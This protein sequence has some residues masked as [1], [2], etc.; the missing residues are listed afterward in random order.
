MKI[1][2]LGG[3]FFFVVSCGVDKERKLG[4]SEE[5]ENISEEMP[6]TMLERLRALGL[7]KDISQMSPIVRNSQMIFGTKG[8]K[9]IV[10]YCDPESLVIKQSDIDDLLEG[11]N[12]ADLLPSGHR[13]SRVLVNSIAYY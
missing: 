8:G 5:Y 2:V 6:S 13:A 7:E 10:F 9:S 12:R 4:G 3:F 11:R 1:L